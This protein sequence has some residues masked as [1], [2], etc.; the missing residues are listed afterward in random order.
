MLIQSL[1]VDLEASRNISKL[2]GS[3]GYLLTVCDGDSA[4]FVKTITVS[5]DGVGDQYEDADTIKLLH[6][7]TFDTHRL[8]G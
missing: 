6:P 1:S 8:V 4:T 2:L 7:P 5:T 3:M